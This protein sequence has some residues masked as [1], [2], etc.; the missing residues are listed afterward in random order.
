MTTPTAQTRTVLL[1]RALEAHHPGL[2]VADLA[3]RAGVTAP[4]VAKDLSGIRNAGEPLE[5]TGLL[6]DPHTLVR[7]AR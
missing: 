7:L 5:A 6:T 3:R 2:T 1:L 4:V